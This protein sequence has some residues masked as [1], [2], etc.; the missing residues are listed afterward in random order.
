VQ[1]ETEVRQVVIAGKLDRHGNCVGSPLNLGSLYWD[2][3]YATASIDLN[4]QQFLSNYRRDENV[5]VT[6]T[7]IRCAYDESSTIM[8]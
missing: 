7:N 4:I 6:P 1:I 8:Y 3:V 2:N 5:V